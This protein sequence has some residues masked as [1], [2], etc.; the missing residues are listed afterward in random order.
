MLEFLL[1]PIDPARAHEVGTHL[2][3]HARLMVL[4]WGVLVP[5]GVLAARFFK[6]LPGQD[7]PREVDNL[8]WWRTH[9]TCQYTSLALMVVALWLILSAPPLVSLPGPHAFIGWAVLCLAVMQ[10]F[11]G[12]LR[13]TKGGPTERAA[14]GSLH[15][16]HYDM[17]PRRL[18]FEYVHKLSGYS[19]LLLSVAAIL[20]GLWQAN[21]PVWMWL[22]LTAW[23]SGLVTAFILLQRRGMAVDTYEAIWG[24]DTAHPGNNRPPIGLG[25]K[26]RGET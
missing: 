12:W 17:T 1:S 21:G 5:T 10:Y 26:R 2:S 8:V 3:W 4:A 15:G 11:G 6:V 7:W 23:W 20:T 9:L 18:W 24:P 25:V 13:G 19:A 22:A 16:D 14:D